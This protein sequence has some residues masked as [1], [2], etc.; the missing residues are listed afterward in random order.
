MDGLTTP[1]ESP[2]G[3]GMRRAIGQ[4]LLCSKCMGLWV[5]AALVTGLVRAPRATRT[6]CT[7]LAAATVN[8]L[9]QTARKVASG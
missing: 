8:D 9:L 6:A 1:R 4:L 5:A 3:R 7:A 2:R